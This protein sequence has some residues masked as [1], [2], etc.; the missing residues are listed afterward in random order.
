ML[1]HTAKTVVH[2]PGR[3]LDACES[4]T[5]GNGSAGQ[6]SVKVFHPP[7]VMKFFVQGIKKLP[8]IDI[9]MVVVRD[10]KL[11]GLD[12]FQ[13]I[14]HQFNPFTACNAFC[15]LKGPVQRGIGKWV[16]RNIHVIFLVYFQQG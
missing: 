4:A 6:E 14:F 9:M 11:D 2:G 1:L 15:R 7:L 13:M 5:L 16:I 12:N 10:I 8:D 3:G